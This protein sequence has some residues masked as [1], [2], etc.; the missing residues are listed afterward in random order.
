MNTPNSLSTE[1]SLI[2]PASESTLV[3]STYTLA[4]KSSSPI[5]QTS[6]STNSLATGMSS[7]PDFDGDGNTDIFWSD[8][9]TGENAIWLMDGGSIKFGGLIQ[10]SSPQEIWTYDFGDFNGDGKTDIFGRNNSTGENLVWLI[11]G[12]ISRLQSGTSIF[13]GAILNSVG[14][15]IEDTFEWSYELGDFNGDGKS[16]VFWRNEDTG[17]N[18]VWIMDGTSIVQNTAIQSLGNNSPAEA[19][20][21]SYELGDF[22]ADGRSDVFWRDYNTGRNYVWWMN[23]ASISFG[24]ELTQLGNTEGTGS[25]D[26]WDFSLADFNGDGRSDVFWRDYDSGR[27]YVWLTNNSGTGIIFGSEL[28][29]LGNTEGTGSPDNWSFGIADFN[30]DGKSDVFWRDNSNGRN[31]TWTMNGASISFGYE[32]AQLGDTAGTGNPEDWDFSFGDF[33]GDD[34]FDIFW[35]ND[36]ESK[37]AVWTLSGG[38]ISGGAFLADLDSDWY[39]SGLNRNQ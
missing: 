23:G 1:V 25:P 28:G 19:Q 7:S 38:T 8:L 16:D 2:L 34:V 22:N 30:G 37:N 24:Y 15:G 35:R 26:D 27:N 13:G 32:L 5:P 12:S 17:E 39:Q 21:W 3:D 36:S 4:T 9:E 11:D 18:R 29:Q 10:S 6:S 33:N 14:S 20:D 31:Y